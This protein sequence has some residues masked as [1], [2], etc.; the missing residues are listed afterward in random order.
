MLL[1]GAMS[2]K[3]VPAVAQALFPLARAVVLTRPGIA[4]AASPDE[5]AA[6][7]GALARDA[8]RVAT[9]PRALARARRLAKASGKG[10]IVVVA[11]SLYLVGA[12]TAAV[13]RRHR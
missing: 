10:T 3:D 6:R 8:H 7:A 5:L 1:F 2:D 9:V 13:A 12:V 11:G 4:R